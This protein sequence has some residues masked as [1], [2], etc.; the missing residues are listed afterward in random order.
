M[1]RMND[2]T[3]EPEELR[4]QELAAVECVFRSGSFI[5]GTARADRRF[6]LNKRSQLVIRVHNETL[7]WVYERLHAGYETH[8]R[9]NQT[10]ICRP[11]HRR[12]FDH[13]YR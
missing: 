7:S 10:Q 5:L 1:I 13:G 12:H 3:S 6:Q 4:R 11:V 9:N 8:Q 2:F